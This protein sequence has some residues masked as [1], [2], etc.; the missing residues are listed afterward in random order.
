MMEGDFQTK[1]TCRSALKCGGINSNYR[2]MNV[3]VCVAGGVKHA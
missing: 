1:P 2:T 3:C